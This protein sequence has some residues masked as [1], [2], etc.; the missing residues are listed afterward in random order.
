MGNGYPGKKRVDEVNSTLHLSHYVLRQ[1]LRHFYFSENPSVEVCRMSI[2]SMND[3]FTHTIFYVNVTEFGQSPPISGFNLHLAMV[4][5]L[6]FYTHFRL[7][8]IS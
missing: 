6:A 5:A 8:A 3:I 2:C 4:L 1:K 7:K